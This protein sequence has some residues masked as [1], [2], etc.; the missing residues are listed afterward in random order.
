VKHESRTALQA[1]CTVLRSERQPRT[2]PQSLSHMAAVRRRRTG[3]DEGSRGR[4]RPGSLG[5]MSSLQED[6]RRT[7]DT[8]EL[9]LGEIA[10]LAPAADA[11]AA[12]GGRR[13]SPLLRLSRVDPSARAAAAPQARTVEPADRRDFHDRLSAVERADRSFRR[14]RRIPPDPTRGADHRRMGGDVAADGDLPVDWWPIRRRVRLLDRLSRM[15]IDLQFPTVGSSSTT[16][17]GH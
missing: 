2:Q 6:P 17:P 15:Q 11:Y 12:D 10:Q 3:D 5:A 8:I 4:R 16:D 14:S 9:K 1:R 13:R 7:D